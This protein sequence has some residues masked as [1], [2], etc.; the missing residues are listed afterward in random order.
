MLTKLAGLSIKSM[1]NVIRVLNKMR[2]YLYRMFN[3]GTSSEERE[4]ERK[5]PTLNL[6]TKCII[7]FIEN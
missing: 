2:I 6:T 1:K 3:I 7:I 4:R 5:R